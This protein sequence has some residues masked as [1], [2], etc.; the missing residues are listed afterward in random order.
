MKTEV[1][2][3]WVAVLSSAL[4]LTWAQSASAYDEPSVNLG[5]SETQRK[6]DDA[7]HSNFSI[8]YEVLPQRLRI[9]LNGY[10]FHQLRDTKV[11]GVKEAGTKEQVIAF[12]PGGVYHFSPHDHLFVNV[13]LRPKWRTGRKAQSSSYAGR[14]T[15]TSDTSPVAAVDIGTQQRSHVSTRTEER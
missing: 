2:K 12:G 6:A 13:F 10:Q 3:I 8:A 11:N 9:G 5:N 15:S 4:L 1:F 14:T 7:I